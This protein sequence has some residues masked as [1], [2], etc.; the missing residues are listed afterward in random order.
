M[1]IVRRATGSAFVPDTVFLKSFLPLPCAAACILIKNSIAGSQISP[2]CRKWVITLG[3]SVFVVMLTEN[4]FRL[5]WRLIYDSL[6]PV[7]GYLS[8][9]VV[10]A[11]VCF[12]CALILGVCIKRTPL[13]RDIF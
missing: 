9:G 1:D 6:N 3:A 5:Q 2:K 4:I 11:V 8:A 10:Y 7:I 12:V 13:L